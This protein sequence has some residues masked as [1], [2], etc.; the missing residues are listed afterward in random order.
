MENRTR[1]SYD[2]I[3]EE[4]AR[5]LSSELRDK[6]FDRDMLDRFAANIERDGLVCDAGCGPGHV[7]RYLHDRGTNVVG[8]DVSPEMIRVAR[9]LNPELRF[10]EGTMTSLPFENESL[11]G[12]VAFYSIVN[13]AAPDID[14]AFREMHR[15]LR[16]DGVV[17]AAFHISDE[18]RELDEMWDIA[19]ALTFFFYTTATIVELF[20][21]AGFVVESRLE[22]E[23]Y[24]PEVE[25]Q[26]RR[27]YLVA[28]KSA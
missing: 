24:A 26:S 8:L 11:A 25:H 3:A 21:A 6:P 18:T 9:V 14:V 2:R 17:L 1:E 16:D 28:R 5:R 7:A 19:V 12:I 22:R 4:Y 23:P 10:V 15:T 20:E 27:A 13:L